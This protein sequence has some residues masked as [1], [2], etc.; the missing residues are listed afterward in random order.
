[1]SAFQPIDVDFDQQSLYN[2]LMS[3]NMF[4]KSFLATVIY[5]DGRSNYDKDGYFE[6]YDDVTH[7]DDNRKLVENKYKTF[8]N[9]NFTYIPGI[10][11][12]ID[13]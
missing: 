10:P 8:V 3:T 9:Y 4:D 2:D 5:T 1:M 6:K 13:T 7:Y 11:K 12:T